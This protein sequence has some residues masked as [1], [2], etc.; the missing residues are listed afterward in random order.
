MENN[1]TV[2]HSKLF[3]ESQ[4]RLRD[5]QAGPDGFLY[6]LTSNQDGRRMPAPGDDRITRIVPLSEPA[7][8]SRDVFTSTS[9]YEGGVAV[10]GTGQLLQYNITGAK[11]LSV[12]ANATDSSLAVAVSATEDGSLVLNMPRTVIDAKLPRELDCRVPEGMLQLASHTLG[13]AA[14]RVWVDGAEADYGESALP[15]ARTLTVEIPAGAKTIKIIG[16]F[17]ASQDP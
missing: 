14:Y 2:P 17:V 1:A 9:V 8:P 3:F 13:D 7:D 16:S 10:R 6:V 11:L 12:A 15:T 4:G 5:V